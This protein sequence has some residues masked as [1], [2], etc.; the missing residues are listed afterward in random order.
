ME[1]RRHQAL[2]EH[3]HGLEQA[4]QAGN[5]LQVAEIAF[6]GPDEQGRAFRAQAGKHLADGP[7]FHGI[8]GGGAGAVRLH[9]AE[10]ADIDV[11]G[12]VEGAQQRHLGV[13]VGEGDADG[14]AV[15]VDAGLVDDGVD[16]VAVGQ[17]GVQGL[18]QQRHPALGPD[19]ALGVGG[20][21]LAAAVGGQH[22]GLGEAHEG[23]RAAQHVH[24]AGDGHGRLARGQGLAGLVQGDQGRGAGRVDGHARAAGV[25]QV[26]NA[27]GQ[28]AQGVAGHGI[29]PDDA[30]VIGASH[31]AVQGGGAH[32]DAGGGAGQGGRPDLGIL[33][34]FPGQFQQQAL[35][36]VH[37]FGFL[38][39]NAEK[40]VVERLD[41][42][43]HAGGERTRPSRRTA[44]GMAEGGYVETFG[45]DLA[46]RV[47]SVRQ[48]VPKRLQG[49]YPARKTAC[50]PN[51]GNLHAA[52]FCRPEA[53]GPSGPPDLRKRVAC[54]KTRCR[55]FDPGPITS[56]TYLIHAAFAP[57][58]GVPR[59]V[60][61]L[62]RRQG[63]D[64][65]AGTP[66]TAPDPVG[67]CGWRAAEKTACEPFRRRRRKEEDEN[68]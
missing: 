64:R 66:N 5:R 37:V 62:K 29:G 7:G 48:Y 21:D 51:Y 49:V 65:W 42:V 9:V 52:S 35:L 57:G 56:K 67:G 41:V 12:V 32:I 63:Q 15:G 24:A 14:A 18:E 60:S 31:A 44:L 33:Q 1:V 45:R 38:P 25:E 55:P 59:Q 40:G 46:D 3:E 58:G 68:V 19:I 28:Q 30:R 10:V 11:R 26:G 43:E 27:V 16:V 17:G 13:L 36:G 53:T 23:Q 8:A 34:D 50:R 54:D 61:R 4:G 2:V 47:P 39:G 6:H 22:V 20:E